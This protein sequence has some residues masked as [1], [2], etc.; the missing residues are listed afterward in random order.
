MAHNDHN[1]PKTTSFEDRF[2]ELT[3]FAYPPKNE[4]QWNSVLTYAGYS[5]LECYQVLNTLGYPGYEGTNKLPDAYLS[6]YANATKDQRLTFGKLPCEAIPLF[7]PDLLRR[8]ENEP[9]GSGTTGAATIALHRRFLGIEKNPVYYRLAN[10]RIRC[11]EQ[12]GEYSRY[13]VGQ[14]S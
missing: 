12:S 13:V 10:A 6:K 3:G 7:G 2:K 4:D 1:K 8:L 14:F 9:T 5:L 11:E